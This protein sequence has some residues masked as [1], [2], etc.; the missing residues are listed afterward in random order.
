MKALRLTDVEAR[1]GARRGRRPDT[2]AGG[3]GDPGRRRRRLPLG[4][5]PHAR[6]RAG[7]AAVGPAVHARPRERRVGGGGR[8]RRR[9][10]RP[11]A[12]RSR[13]TGLGLRALPPLHARH[14]E[15]LR[16]PGPAA[17]RRAAGSAST[18]GWRRTCWCRT[19]RWLVPL[20]DLDP[21]VAAPL[22]DAGLTPVPRRQ[23]L[24]APSWC[25]A[26]P[27]S[28]I[29]VGGLGHLGVQFLA[30]LSPATVIAVDQR[31]EALDLAR[32]ARRPPHRARRARR[33]GDEITRADRRAPGPRSCST[34]SA[35]TPPCS[36]PRRSPASTGRPHHRRHRRRQ[37]D[38]RVLR[39]PVRGVGRD[40]VLGHPVGARR[41]A[42][43]RRGRADPH[44]GDDVPARPAPSRPT[45]RSHAGTVD[46]RAV[47]T[48]NG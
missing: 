37:P 6:L 25:R 32:Q 8:R 47:I 9:R 4:P 18:A 26:R 39:R 17:G 2:G 48:P 33:R 19:A 30:A 15:L 7:A 40:D 38:G 3:G 21:V 16:A 5:P 1:T 29:G 45:A 27:R 28:S 14:G 12:T 43:P 34:S 10:A 13:S 36:S 42:R 31:Q 11:R 20:G 46:G 23:A 35:S 24:A 41:G 44:D 22:T